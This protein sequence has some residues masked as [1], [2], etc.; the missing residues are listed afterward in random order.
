MNISG[1]ADLVLMCV[2][3][4]ELDQKIARYRELAARVLDAKLA[5]GL[6]ELI[7]EAEAEKAALH[8]ER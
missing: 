2:K 1:A 6:D 3:C 4:R 8:S 7:A 5:E